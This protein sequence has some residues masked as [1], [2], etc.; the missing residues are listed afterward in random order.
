VSLSGIKEDGPVNTLQG[1]LQ[2]KKELYLFKHR[3][4]T[5]DRAW[6]RLVKEVAEEQAKL[7][8]KMPGEDAQTEMKAAVESRGPL[9][10]F[11]LEKGEAEKIQTAMD[12]AN[13]RRNGFDEETKQNPEELARMAEVLVTQSSTRPAKAA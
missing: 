7:Y 12:W 6:G 8:G 2:R 13:A 4:A 9:I 10:T 5:K 11:S 1:F 3:A